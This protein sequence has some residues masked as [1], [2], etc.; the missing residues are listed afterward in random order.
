MKEAWGPGALPSGVAQSCIWSQ[1]GSGPQRPGAVSCPRASAL[2]PFGSLCAR[3]SGLGFDT[4]DL[5]SGGKGHV[6]RRVLRK[7]WCGSVPFRLPHAG[8]LSFS[9]GPYLVGTNP[10]FRYVLKGLPQTNL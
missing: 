8:L 3:T 1:V 2:W 5:P 4:R 9:Q 7:T 6:G 10:E